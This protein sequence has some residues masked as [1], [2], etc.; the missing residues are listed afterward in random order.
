MIEDKIRA[1]P[2][3]QLRPHIFGCLVFTDL[4]LGQSLKELSLLSINIISIISG[5]I[6]VG[7]FSCRMWANKRKVAIKQT[8]DII[9]KANKFCSEEEAERIIIKAFEMMGIKYP[10][11]VSKHTKSPRKKHK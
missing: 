3:K 8:Q 2:N 6:T 1:L 7:E 11:V 4:V 10:P 5:L 9:D